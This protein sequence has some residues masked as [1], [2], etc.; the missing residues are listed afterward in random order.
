MPSLNEIKSVIRK[1]ISIDELREN[2]CFFGG[3]TPYLICQE[4]S[5]RDHS[6]IDILVNE[7][8][9][10]EIRDLLKLYNIYLPEKDSLNLDLGEDYGVK[11]F[12]N[13]VYVEFEPMKNENN[14]LIRKSFS[15]RRNLVGI[16]EMSYEDISDVIVP[17]DF[18]GKKIYVET[19][20][21]IR[22][23]KS[24]YQREKDKADIEFIDK[25]GIDRE[26]YQRVKKGLEESKQTLSSYE[27]S[28]VK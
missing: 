16:E 14:C 26:K 4:E 15:P 22:A 8:Y 1:I 25:H 10:E 28:I 20:E 23:D 11:T 12:I 13:G 5:G 3:A 6:D 24:T 19:L 21:L 2:I 18:E 7:E 17:I 9:M 27:S